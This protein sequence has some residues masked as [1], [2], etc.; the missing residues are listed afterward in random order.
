MQS[1][2]TSGEYNPYYGVFIDQ[3]ENA[4][5]LTGL[6][7][8]KQKFI[9][10][11][12]TIFDEKLTYAYAEGKWT[13]AEVLQHIIDTER[14]FSYRALRF[15]RNDKSP[16]IGF[17]QD[18]YVPNSNANNYSRQELIED[19]EAARN[20]SIGLFKSFTQNMLTEIGEA[21]GSPMSV[22]AIGY[23]LSGHQKHHLHVIKDRYL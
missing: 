19:F 18:E 12:N 9:D 15:A 14:I 20:N 10:F 8:S 11:V 3:A 23:V 2:L 13:I 4:N 22:R 6:Q 16:L 7:Q 21:S 17:D 1:L 5:I